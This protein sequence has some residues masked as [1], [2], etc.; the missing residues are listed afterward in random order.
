MPKGAG[1][2]IVAIPRA[3][4]EVRGRLVVLHPF[5]PLDLPWRLAYLEDQRVQDNMDSGLAAGEKADMTALHSWYSRLRDDPRALLLGVVALG[6]A[7]Y[8]GDLTILRHTSN[9]GNAEGNLVMF[10]GDSH[11]WN[12]GLEEDALRACCK[13]AFSS[14]DL[15]R[16][17]TSICPAAVWLGPILARAGFQPESGPTR[18]ETS[19]GRFWVAYRTEPGH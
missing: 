2:R 6:T 9:D 10:F 4:F 19:Q 17:R 11:L 13:Y 8:V 18:E 14:L 12:R 1:A 3:S 15:E 5:T 7:R 16:L